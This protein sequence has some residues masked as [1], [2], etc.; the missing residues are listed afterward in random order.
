MGLDARPD[1]LNRPAELCS[2]GIALRRTFE[3]DNTGRGSDVA[4][5][6]WWSSHAAARAPSTRLSHS[7]IWFQLVKIWLS[8]PETLKVRIY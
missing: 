5:S 1:G 6:S 8:L 2:H 3:N 7:A 4:A